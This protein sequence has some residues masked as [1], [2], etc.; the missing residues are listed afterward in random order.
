MIDS[1]ASTVTGANARTVSPQRRQPARHDRVRAHRQ[2]ER[3][4]PMIDT[5]SSA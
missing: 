4:N 1:L 5:R 3:S 2:V